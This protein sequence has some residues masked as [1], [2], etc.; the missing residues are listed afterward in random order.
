VA[1]QLASD[2]DL[3]PGPSDLDFGARRGGFRR[4]DRRESGGWVLGEIS[5]V[6]DGDRE[7][8][9]GSGR[10]PV[11]TAMRL[12][13]PLCRTES[14]D[15]QLPASLA[16]PQQI[17]AALAVPRVHRVPDL[18]YRDDLGPIRGTT[19]WASRPRWRHWRRRCW[20][21]SDGSPRPA[22]PCRHAVTRPRTTGI[23]ALR[24]R[25]DGCEA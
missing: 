16:R 13:C 14:N 17:S 7:T 6:R 19:T 20:S 11:H 3:D 5:P 22:R 8:A 9:P 2:P 25:R 4:P 18:G 21:C 23:G 15:R 1:R 10:S 24:P 12:A